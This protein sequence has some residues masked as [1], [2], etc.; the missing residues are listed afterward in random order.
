MRAFAE[1]YPDFIASQ[2]TLLP[3]GRKKTGKGKPEFVQSALA[4]IE[5]R[6]TNPI[7]Q[8]MLAQLTWY[9]HIT[10]LDK[11]KGHEERLFCINKAIENGWS[12]SVM[13]LQIENNLYQRRGQLINNFDATMLAYGSD[14]AKETFKSPHLFDFFTLGEDAKEKEVERGLIQPLKKFMLELGRG[15]AYMGNQYT[16]TWTSQ[17]QRGKYLTL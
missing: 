14:L 16:L 8:A 15:F 17:N 4:Q 7:V 12:R 5:D 10:L 11:V 2:P 3:S 13:V 9:H 1:A 6:P